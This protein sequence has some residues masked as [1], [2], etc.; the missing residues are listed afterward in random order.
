MH[1]GPAVIHLAGLDVIQFKTRESPFDH[2]DATDAGPP[3]E[4]ISRRNRHAAH[5]AEAADGKIGT[6]IKSAGVD[7]AARVALTAPQ[8]RC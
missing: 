5:A 2:N 3:S 4:S 1:T 7:G 8:V 6:V